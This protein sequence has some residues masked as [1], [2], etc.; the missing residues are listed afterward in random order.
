M[1]PSLFPC[2]T[3]IWAE[4]AGFVGPNA[5]MWFIFAI[6]VLDSSQKFPL[7]R[8]THNVFKQSFSQAVALSN[9]LSSPRLLSVLHCSENHLQETVNVNRLSEQ[10]G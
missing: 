1:G 2:N 4:F 3:T 5:Y 9:S 6:E 10:P 8:S 7:D